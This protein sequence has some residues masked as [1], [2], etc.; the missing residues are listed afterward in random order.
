MIA[1]ARAEQIGE[2]DD[3]LVGAIT[4]SPDATAVRNRSAAS[5]IESALAS[6]WTWV[7]TDAQPA[8]STT[9]LKALTPNLSRARLRHRHRPRT[10]TS[11]WK[12]A[13]TIAV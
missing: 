2:V 6:W 8:V 4:S 3:G 13:V 10:A 12:L 5:T 11:Y 7:S 1:E 9:R